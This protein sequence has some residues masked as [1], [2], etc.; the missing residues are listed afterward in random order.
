ML[1]NSSIL[2]HFTIGQ[3]I[4]TEGKNYFDT[5]LLLIVSD[6][7]FTREL[8]PVLVEKHLA[9]HFNRLVFI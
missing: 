2:Y 3:T 1:K 8:D 9:L 7:V 4:S 5:N 6:M